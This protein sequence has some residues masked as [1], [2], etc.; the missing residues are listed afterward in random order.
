[1]ILKKISLALF[2][3][4][5]FSCTKSFSYENII[6]SL[7]IDNSE[8]SEIEVLMHKNQ[9]YVPCKYFLHYFEVPYKENHAQKS[10]LY[11]NV[12]VKSDSITIDGIKQK[13]SGFF[14]KSGITDIQNE[15]FVPVELLSKTLDKKFISNTQ[16]LAVYVITGKSQEQ[17]E[18]EF[19][20]PFII[21]DGKIKA[22]A[23]D[24]IIL[25]ER[26][27]LFSLDSIGFRNNMISDTYSQIYKDSECK[28]V[29][30]NSNTKVT[31]KGQL[32][33]GDY[34][35]DMGTNSY[36]ENMFA[37]SGISPQYK[38]QYHKFDYLLGKSDSWTFAGN[39]V[40]SDLMGVQIKDHIEENLT[41]QDIEGYVSPSSTVKVYIN[42]DF[43]KELNTYGGYYSLKDLYYGNEIKT[44]KI[45][46]ILADGLRNEIFNNTFSDNIK[47]KK[48]P[49]HDFLTGITGLQNR[50]WAN[51]GNIYQSDTKKLVL[52]YKHNKNISEKL[53]LE[54]LVIAD[55]IISSQNSAW[56]RSILGNRKYLNY[57]TMKNMNVLQGETYLGSVTYNNSKKMDSRLTF[58]GSNSTSVDE[59]TD[60][61]LGYYLKYEN[62]YKLDKDSSITGSLFAISP[63]FYMAGSSYGGS[64][65]DRVG[66]SIGAQ[67]NFK[68]LFISTNCSKYKSNFG[69]YYDG[70]L[71]DFDEYNILFRTNFKKAP[72]LSLKLNNKKGENNIGQISSSAY[73]FSAYK[74]FKKLN[75]KGGLRKNLYEN[76][77]NFADYSGYSSEYSNIFTDAS[78]PIGKKFG[79]ILIGHELVETK[80]DSTNNNYKS[81]KINY[82]TPSFKGVSCNIST[83][84]HYS[85]TTK[86]N[87]FG[88]GISKRLKSGSTVNLNY[89]YSVI[90]CYL[91]DNMYIPGSMRH[92]VTIDFAEL[93][94][95]G[96]SGLQGI[97][98]TNEDKGILQVS[99]FLDVN[100][101]GIKD[102]DESTIED[103]PIKIDDKSETI[104]LKKCKKDNL[105]TA[106]KGVH[107]IKV[108]EDE[109]PT[110][111]S[112]CN[113]TKAIRY[114]KV[115]NNSK[116]K[117]DFG[118]ISTVGNINGSITVKDEYNNLLN[119]PDLVVSILNTEGREVTYANINEDGTFSFSGLS[120]GKYIVAVD[121]E[122]QELYR[123]GPE[124]NSESYMIEIPPQYKDYVN[125][126]NVNLNYK[127]QL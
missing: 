125:I 62:N 28:N 9:M 74:R 113:K 73:E 111:L 63:E 7:I 97:G 104:L 49:T 33:S 92:S 36:S 117:V 10:L 58:G 25:P 103:I 116:T 64:I 27:G 71:L 18:E 46:E 29:S 39:E 2:I 31:L 75:F 106:A 108:C 1:M 17:D 91:I 81:I 80:S 11:K 83:G 61:G 45:E 85:G 123:I 43:E 3:L 6:S 115:N 98:T 126:D 69:K 15:F 72:S 14:L 105:I 56:G 112:V 110:F 89:R 21:K 42:D 22:K 44:L 34:K 102:K 93:Y 20:N 57:T 77:Y 65:A 51:N 101:N 4:L 86:G 114:V 109:L 127:Y 23:Y 67:K 19:Q 38:N 100:Q 82:T 5:L 37:F 16:E 13:Y 59:I 90:P 88:L 32:A 26:K 54:N 118:L 84:L 120:P 68:K 48:I 50:L 96:G 124:S 41:Y 40:N 94:G 122:I 121:K 78:F 55:H 70:G 12:E 8:E 107:S 53:Q 35:L 95:I 87:D 52:G 30:F 66:G 47:K 79:N 24:E 60:H 119:F 76:K 99:A